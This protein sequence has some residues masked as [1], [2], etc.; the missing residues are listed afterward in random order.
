ML[1]RQRAFNTRKQNSSR[2]GK[3]DNGVSPSKMKKKLV[4]K[5]D[6]NKGKYG[7]GKNYSR[8]NSGEGR[9]HYG[10]G[11]GPNSRSMGKKDKGRKKS[12]DKKSSRGNLIGKKKGSKSSLSQ[13]KRSRGGSQN[14][15]KAKQKHKPDNFYQVKYCKKWIGSIK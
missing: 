15:R 5:M 10:K 14:K 6:D 9:D 2:Q 11:K 8:V 12:M 13:N 3:Y 7:K 4:N 1:P